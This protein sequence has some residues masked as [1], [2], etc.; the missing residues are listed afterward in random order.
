M[1]ELLML[2]LICP[3]ELD[4][5]LLDQLLV[6]CPAAVFTS[7]TIAC[8]GATR[9][10]LS[11]AEQV[12]G[13]SQSV[14]IQILLSRVEIDALMSLLREAFKGV[15]VRYWLSPILDSGEMT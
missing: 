11:P 14:Q 13:R 1:S 4:E 6:S 2:T 15:G 7:Q 12:L 10:P 9:L 3:P 5:K 8:H